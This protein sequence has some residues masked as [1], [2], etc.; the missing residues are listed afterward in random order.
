MATCPECDAELDAGDELEEG[1]RLECPECEA[2]LEVVTTNPLELNVIAAK[3][4]E[5]EETY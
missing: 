1:Q 2:M 3:D 5:E 4:E